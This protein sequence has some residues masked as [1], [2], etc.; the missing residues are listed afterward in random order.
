MADLLWRK[1]CATINEISQDITL[2]NI[3]DPI[4]SETTEEG[5]PIRKLF[6]GNLAERTTN[7]DL[8]KL[9]SNYGKVNSCYIKRN[10]GKSNFAF[11]TFNDVEGGI[12]AR[13]A[14]SRME[15]QLHCRILRVS[16]ANSWHQP[17]SVEN[18][19]RFLKNKLDDSD[20][21]IKI[22]EFIEPDFN[23][24]PIHIL[25]DDCLMEIFLY[26]PIADR[27]RTERVCK[28][29]QAVSQESWR[30]VKSL[31]LEKNTWGLS[32]KIRI[33]AV[34]TTTLRKVLIRC[35]QYLTN[36]DLSQYPHLLSSSTLTIVGKFCPNLQCINIKALELSPSGIYSLMNNCQSI[37][38][39]TIKSLTGP[40]EKDLSQLFN[41]NKKLKYFAVDGDGHISGKCLE[42]LPQNIEEIHLNCCLS[43]VSN[44]FNLA[45]QKFNNLHSLTLNSC[46]CITDSTLET[47]GEIKTIINLEFS[48]SNPMI[49]AISMNN[50]AK[51]I[52]LQQLCL[53]QNLAVTDEFLINISNKCKKLKSLD[54]S[55]CGAVTNKG[56]N[57][58]A[59]LTELEILKLKWL[60]QIT[61]EAFENFHNIKVLECWSC[62]NIRDRGIIKL[63]EMAP[64]LR[65]LDL[66]GCSI[67]NDAIKAAI[68][69]TLKRTNNIVLQM[70]VGGNETNL[71]ELYEISPWLLIINVD[72]SLL[73]NIN[74]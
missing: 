52:N 8:Q 25:N 2:N 1:F 13:K 57:A 62:T 64:N 43:L 60:V 56:I 30:A 22:H 55:Y 70:I 19:R 33:R 42:Y 54:I 16:S 41:V 39:L 73:G 27:I 6:I 3:P 14:A 23:E 32:S 15:I 29:W 67:T 46:V 53:S 26:L 36:L 12:K 5:V 72:L 61:D 65:T 38:K 37:N 31:D 4:I 47:I 24:S 21:S 63:I 34:D 7:K 18:Q 59:T 48:G 58:I 35:G 20:E 68:S 74:N 40:C 45:L 10:N 44:H 17:D 49:S 50:L 28:R 69:I 11:I 9:F 66:S 51:L 71:Q